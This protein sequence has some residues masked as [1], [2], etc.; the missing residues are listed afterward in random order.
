MRSSN[1]IFVALTGLASSLCVGARPLLALSISNSQPVIRQT[2]SPGE[3]V[4]GSIELVSYQTTPIRVRTYLEDWRYTSV[5]DG[6]KEFGPPQ[7]FPRSCAS[8]ISFFP[9]EIMLPANGKT[10]VDYTIR[11]PED[12]S[13]DGGYVAVLFFEASTESEASTTSE[14]NRPKAAV[15]FA[16]RLGSLIL[17]DIK[18]TVRREG[19]LSALS[20]SSPTE[21]GISKIH[22]LLSNEGNTTLA[23][24]GSF[25]VMGSGN[26][27]IGRGE[28][29]TR[30]VWPGDHV[31]VE[32]SWR[33]ASNGTLILTYDCGQELILVEELQ[34]PPS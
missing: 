25:S 1:R 9:N 12:I 27:V 8:W 29:P 34:V 13:L 4:Q 11:I 21:S 33:G 24:E 16:A 10:V 23:C 22:A 17:V 3:T 26:L 6:S 20:V 14:D 18:G 2:L 15:R 19:R 5:G 30:Y 7:T 31:P 32:A 28:L